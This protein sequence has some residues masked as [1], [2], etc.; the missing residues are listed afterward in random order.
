MLFFTYDLDALRGG[1]PRLLL[2]LR[3]AGARARCCATT[4]E[5]GEALRDLDAVA[6]APRRPLPRVRRRPTASSTTAARRRGSSTG[7]S[8]DP[9]RSAG[10]GA[11]G[12]ARGRDVVVADEPHGAA[13]VVEDVLAS[14]QC[15]LSGIVLLGR[16]ADV[17]A[18]RLA[19]LSTVPWP[20]SYEKALVLIAWP[21]RS[22][23]PAETLVRVTASGR[24]GCAAIWIASCSGSRQ[25]GPQ[26]RSSTRARCPAGR[27][28]TRRR[29]A[30]SRRC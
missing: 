16:P 5:V 10:A 29:R 28:G 24:V 13:G 17:Q 18:Q 30:P 4:D 23:G 12:D 19:W 2:R 7:S 11:P 27:T 21:S 14:P 3:G 20:K 6:A 15:R 8:A 26:G 9:G 22:T 25:V 1:D